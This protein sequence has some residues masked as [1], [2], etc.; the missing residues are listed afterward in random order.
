MRAPRLRLLANGG[1]VPGAVEAEIRSNNHYAADRFHVAVA[2]GAMAVAPWAASE[3]IQVELQVSLD[4]GLGWVSLVQGSV[5]RVEI[6]PVTRMLWLDGRD[7]T[8]ALIEARTQET[9][10]NRT[11]SEIATLLAARHGLCA[12][13]QA[14]TTLVGRYWQ[15]D[16]D[17]ITLDQF[18]RAITEWDLLV[19]LAQ[20]EG[21]DV[22]VGGATLH[23]RAARQQAGSPTVLRAAASWSGSANVTALRL[24]RSLTLACDIEVVVK[25]WNAR[26]QAAFLQTAR[27]RRDG[28]KAGR[29]P[30][31]YV[32]VVPNL[33]PDAALQLAQRRLAEL[34]RHERV[35]I[36]EMPGD[37]A[38]LPRMQVVLEG[39]GTTFDQV[40]WVDEV[41][42]HLSVGGGFTQQVRARNASVGSQATSPGDLVQSQGGSASWTGF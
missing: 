22:W 13:V 20:H 12:D 31:R 29:P 23:F 42:R 36:A 24:E 41:D 1:E 8:A 37:L 3:D 14:T 6:D 7:R 35:I 27:V 39:S 18:S 26:Q 16:H 2:L 25:S 17:R 21:F 19:T 40:Y 15:M 4:G 30:Q 10:A 32:Y 28:A 9:F 33:T 5:D 34:T 11:A 38:L